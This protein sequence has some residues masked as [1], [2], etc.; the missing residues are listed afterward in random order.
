[1]KL[2]RRKNEEGFTF[3]ELIMVIVILGILS[4]V[5]V[6][7]YINLGDTVKLGVARGVGSAISATIDTEHSD[8]LI[9][10]TPY[11]M[12]DVLAGI[13]FSGGLAYSATEGPPGIGE[14]TTVTAN[15]TIG[16]NIKGDVFRWT[17]T[18]QDG[19]TPALITEDSTTAFP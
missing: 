7:K 18:P 10:T 2:I 15:T 6:P 11:T 14:V 12:T 19:D 9:N 4:S 5:A 1:M 3:I 13:S 8:Y 17:W 16:A